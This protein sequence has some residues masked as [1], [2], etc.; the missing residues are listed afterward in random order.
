MCV[1]ACAHLFVMDVFCVLC[2]MP[3]TVLSEIIKRAKKEPAWYIGTSVRDATLTN[4]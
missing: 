1:C 4:V 3:E 2:Q